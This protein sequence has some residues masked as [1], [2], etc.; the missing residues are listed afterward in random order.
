[1]M[2]NCWYTVRPEVLKKGADGVVELLFKH[3]CESGTGDG[4]CSK[5]SLSSR[6]LTPNDP[7]TP[8]RS[9][10]REKRLRSMMTKKAAGWSLMR[11]Y[12]SF[13]FEADR[14]AETLGYMMQ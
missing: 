4:G 2:N 13:L 9:T 12:M 14:H 7:E 5:S 11:R 6:L 8:Q 3:P 10:S 1:M